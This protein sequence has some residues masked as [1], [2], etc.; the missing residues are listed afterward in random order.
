MDKPRE[1][2]E[3]HEGTSR[4][5]KCRWRRGGGGGGRRVGRREEGRMGSGMKGEEVRETTREGGGGEG[6]NQDW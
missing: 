6:R 1:L 2:Q 5:L 3:F 4:S